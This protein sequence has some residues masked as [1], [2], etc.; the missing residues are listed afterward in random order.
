MLFFFFKQK[1]A[2]EIRNCDWSSDVCSS[3]LKLIKRKMNS[4]KEDDDKEEVEDDEKNIDANL[5]TLI[6]CSLHINTPQTL[7]F[8]CSC[9]LYL[10]QLPSPPRHFNT[11]SSQPPLLYLLMGIPADGAAPHY[12]SVF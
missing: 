3:D 10:L 4:W 5:T 1:T 11:T 8:F 9:L 6:P 2:Y 7:R 12:C